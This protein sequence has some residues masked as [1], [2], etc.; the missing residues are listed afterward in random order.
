MKSKNDVNYNNKIGYLLDLR[1]S[2]LYDYFCWN[3]PLTDANLVVS[4]ARE[5]ILFVGNDMILSSCCGI[6]GGY[7][8]SFGAGCIS[9][10]GVF[11]MYHKIL[12]GYYSTYE[13]NMLDIGLSRVPKM[14]QKIK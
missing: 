6:P 8:L 9:N 11:Y 13:H 12:S 7:N 14:K 10:R 3:C 1:L 5:I 4:I 2:D